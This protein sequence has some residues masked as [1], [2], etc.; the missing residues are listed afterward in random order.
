MRSIDQSWGELT[1]DIQHQGRHIGS[2]LWNLIN[3]TAYETSA[4]NTAF[5]NKDFYVV[6]LIGF[7]LKTKKEKLLAWPRFSCPTPVY[8]QHVF[9]YHHE[10]T[11]LEFLWS[12]PNKEKCAYYIK[13]Y[14]KLLRDPDQQ[15]QTTMCLMFDSGQ[16]LEWVKKENKED[17]E[18]DGYFLTFNAPQESQIIQ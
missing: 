17:P 3:K 6:A 14:H 2:L 11:A 12:L 7:D 8:D 16:L 4:N 1:D 13:N 5:H 9:K 10:S 15:K 18:L